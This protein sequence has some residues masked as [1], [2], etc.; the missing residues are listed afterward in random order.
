MSDGEQGQEDPKIIPFHLDRKAFGM[1]V[2]LSAQNEYIEGI[3]FGSGGSKLYAAS[4]VG[5]KDP[6]EDNKIVEYD[7]NRTQGN[8]NATLINF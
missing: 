1:P 4:D 8:R 2:D 7:F 6:G 3:Y 5:L